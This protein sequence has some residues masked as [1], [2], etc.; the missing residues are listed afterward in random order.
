MAVM[1][2]TH[3]EYFSG[4]TRGRSVVAGRFSTLALRTAGGS[5]GGGG[6]VDEECD[7][8][9]L[10]AGSME[11]WEMAG[12]GHFVVVGDR[13]ESVPGDDVGL[14]WCTV[15]SPADF[16]LRLSWMRWRHEDSS[17]IF[18]RFPRP[19]RSSVPNPAVVAAAH[20]FEVQID[21]L[22][23]PDAASIHKTGAI[24]DEAAQHVTPRTARPEAEWNDFEIVVQGECY[25]VTLNGRRVTTFVNSDL[26]RGRPSTAEAPSFIGL[27]I[28]PGSRVAFRN[29]RIKAL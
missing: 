7:F 5:S 4:A 23:L 1:D 21:E 13:L 17:G 9:P 12:K 10:F 8:T 15:P 19:P 28:L 20:G 24:F 26:R 2:E 29:L 6:V 16:V 14:F 25:S 11:N 22:G 18:V 27:Q 3:Y